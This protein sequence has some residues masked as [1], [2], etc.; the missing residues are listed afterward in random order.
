MILWFSM[1]FFLCETALF[2]HCKS[3]VKS[4]IKIFSILKKISITSSLAIGHIMDAILVYHNAGAC[5]HF[6]KKSSIYFLWIEVSPFRFP[7]ICYIHSLCAIQWHF[8]YLS[9]KLNYLLFSKFVFYL[10]VYVHIPYLRKFFPLVCSGTTVASIRKSWT[11]PT[12]FM[13]S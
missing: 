10:C 8:Y 13:L 2:T 9:V 1:Y 4:T 6:T 12:E 5:R 11:N 3:M 7:F